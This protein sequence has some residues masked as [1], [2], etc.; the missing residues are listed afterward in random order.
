MAQ[1][2]SVEQLNRLYSAP[3]PIVENKAVY[4]LDSHIK[5][6]IEHSPF[7]VLSSRTSENLLDVSPRGGEPGFIKIL[8]DTH[9]LIPDSPGNNRLDTIKNLLVNPA[10]GVLFTIPGINEVVRLKGTASIHDDP[11][12]LAGCPDGAKVPKLV[13]KIAIQEMYFHCPKAMIKGKIWS[14]D[15]QTSRSILPSLGLIVKEQQGLVDIG[16]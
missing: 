16:E 7:V 9:L 13:I 11:E 6:F 3:H 14:N 4:A 8:D 5:T 15:A 10:I 12:L 2:T 1:I